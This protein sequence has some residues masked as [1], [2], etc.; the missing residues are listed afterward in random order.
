MCECV[1]ELT[2]IQVDD[3]AGG[4]LRQ[5]VEGVSCDAPQSQFI[6]VIPV[7]IIIIIIIIIN[8]V[9]RCVSHTRK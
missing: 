8:Y 7:I 3:D 4:A 9:L 1:T 6:V 2:R 5:N